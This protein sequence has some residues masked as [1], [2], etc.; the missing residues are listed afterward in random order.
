MGTLARLH[1][2]QRRARVPILL[3]TETFI[4]DTPHRRGSPKLLASFA[5][6]IN[7]TP[8]ALNNRNGILARRKQSLLILLLVSLVLAGGSA[9][10]L[11]RTP[12]RELPAEFIRSIDG[13]DAKLTNLIVGS[14][15]QLFA[16]DANGRVF[17]A[18]FSAEELKPIEPI[19]DAA[20]TTIAFSSDDLLMAA[21]DSGLLRSWQLPKFSFASVESPKVPT[22]S[23]VF[24]GLDGNLE[25]LLGLCDGRI[26]RLG[27]DGTKVFKTRH[28]GIKSMS[29][30]PD[31]KT[32]VVGGTSGLVT[33]FDAASIEAIAAINNH[34][35]EVASVAWSSDGQRI[36]CG[37]WDGLVTIVAAQDF[38][39]IATGQQADAV[40]CLRWL[41]E[42]LVTSSWGGNVRQWSIAKKS[43]SLTSEFNTNSVVHQ[44]VLNAA[45]DTVV[46]V[47]GT[48]KLE[49]WKMP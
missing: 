22:T 28:R 49:F 30:S 29:L 12:T 4:P 37:D 26:V 47:S 8:K 19:G 27:E 44:F 31:Q 17:E 3:V 1:Y 45:G 42:Q 11:L 46:T 2:S 39:V 6:K 40:S 24:R 38:K 34:K 14:D 21:D 16:A 7:K 15:D 10:I 25:I 9:W 48:D 41:N 43:L 36:A 33:F 18:S 32:L 5:T 35:T 23:I 13:S 20:V